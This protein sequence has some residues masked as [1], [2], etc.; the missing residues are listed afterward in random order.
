MPEIVTEEPG[1]TVLP[2]EGDVI[3]DVGGVVS[4][5]AIAGT[6]PPCSVAG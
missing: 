1:D 3:A 5:E 6:S 4:V 2:D